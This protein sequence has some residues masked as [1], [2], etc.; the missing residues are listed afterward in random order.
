MNINIDYPAEFLDSEIRCDYEISTKMKKIWLIELDLLS[1]LKRVC[2][3]YGLEY[4]ADSGTLIGAVRHQGFIP[5]DDDIDIVMKRDDYKKLQEIASE[6]FNEPYFLQCAYS[7]EHCLRGYSRLRNSDST[8]IGRSDLYSGTNHG[9][10]IDIFPLDN[11]PDD[12]TEREKW[13]KKIRKTYAVIRSTRYLDLDN[14][15]VKKKLKKPFK[16]VVDAILRVYGYDRY[17]KKYEQLCS[18]YNSEDTKY[19][20]Y[21]AYSLGKTKHI[22]EKKCFDSVEV[23]PFEFTDINVPVGYDSRLRTEYGDYMEIVHQS[24]R[25]GELVC[26]PDIPYKI[27]E[28]SNSRKELW[29]MLNS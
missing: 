17:F 22:W 15:S 27:F 28:K 9:V 25:H 20:S 11:V 10:F 29:S 5:W 8:A 14:S 24:T 21:V 18:R 2:L 13:L 19:M 16:I 4:Y 7:D 26:E 6:E 3:K 12:L 23:M 1:E